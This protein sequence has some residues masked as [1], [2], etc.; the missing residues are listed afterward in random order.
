MSEHEIYGL[1]GLDDQA[2][3]SSSEEEEDEGEP[4]EGTD[5]CF[6]YQRY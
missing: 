2:D 5:Q 4:A 6:Y 3:A 1:N